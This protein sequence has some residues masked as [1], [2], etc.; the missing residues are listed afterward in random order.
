MNFIGPNPTTDRTSI[1]H[2]L[3]VSV[4]GTWWVDCESKP[5]GP[6]PTKEA[7]ISST[8]KLIE[9]FG[10]P[11]RPADIWAPDETGRSKLIW[12]REAVRQPR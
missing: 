10:D 8:M 6:M 12:K 7:A 9:A 5:F 2:Y 11:N 3:V 1:C 4:D